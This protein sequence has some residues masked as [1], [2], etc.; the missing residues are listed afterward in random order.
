MCRFLLITLSAAAV[1]GCDNA[2]SKLTSMP[3]TFA[4]M[5]GSVTELCSMIESPGYKP[6]RGPGTDSD[7]SGMFLTAFLKEA[8][9]GSYEADAQAISQKLIELDK[10]VGS[11]ASVD[12]QRA[13]A[14]ELQAAVAALKS[15]MGG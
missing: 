7:R 12:K 10:L 1:I 6:S 8:T 9:G 5:E 2:G 14:K 4:M 3:V 11:R 15:K 13:A